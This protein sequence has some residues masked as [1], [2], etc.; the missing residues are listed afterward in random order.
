V[1]ESELY[2]YDGANLYDPADPD[3]WL[4]SSNV[5]IDDPNLFPIPPFYFISAGSFYE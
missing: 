3:Y 4:Y 1:Q 2:G 5:N